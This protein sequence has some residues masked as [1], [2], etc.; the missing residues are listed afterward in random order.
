[1]SAMASQSPASRLFAYL[2]VH[3]EIKESIKAPHHWTLKGIYRWPVDSPHKGPLTQKVFPF[4]DV[5]MKN[6]LPC[7][8]QIVNQPSKNGPTVWFDDRS[9]GNISP[10]QMIEIIHNHH[11]PHVVSHAV[12]NYIHNLIC[13][14]K[15]ISLGGDYSVHILRMVKSKLL[16]KY[17]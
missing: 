8:S 1:M 17:F 11:M 4:D 3:T 5:I 15:W 13:R 10:F 2:F 12:L 6:G 16:G 7:R 9:M 14:S